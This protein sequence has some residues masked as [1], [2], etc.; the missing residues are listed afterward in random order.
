M[1]DLSEDGLKAIPKLSRGHTAGSLI[2]GIL[3]SFCV[4]RRLSPY[5]TWQAEQDPPSPGSVGVGVL[6]NSN[7]GGILVAQAFGGRGRVIYRA[8]SRTARATYRNH[9][10]TPSMTPEPSLPFA[11]TRLGCRTD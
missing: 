6:K 11:Y 10:P 3:P 9:T 4:D 7:L 8:S 5:F 2:R 1:K